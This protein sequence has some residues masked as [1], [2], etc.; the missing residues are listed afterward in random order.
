[1]AERSEAVYLCAFTENRGAHEMGRIRRAGFRFA[2]ACFVG[3]PLVC[4]SLVYLSLACSPVLAADAPAPLYGRIDDARLRKAANEPANWL[5]YGGTYSEQRYSPLD[6][7]NAQTIAKLAPAWSFDFDTYRG[8]ESTPIVVDGVMYVTTAWSKVYAL[9]AKTGQQIWSHDPE[10]PGGAGPKPCCDVVNRGA[11]V[12]KGKVYVGTVDGR[13]IALDAR[14]GNLAWSTLTVDSKLMHSITGAPRVANGKVFI[15]NGGG[16]FGGRGYVSAYDAETGKLVWR[17]YTVPKDPKLPKDGAASDDA[18]ARIALPTW[19]GDWPAYKGGG[20]PWNAIVYDP[21]FNQLYIATGNGFPLNRKFRSDA[22]GD[23][24]FI[25][26]IVALN[27][28]TGKYRWHYQETP[29]DSWD[30]DSVQDMML[31][32]LKIGVESRKVL[33][34][35]PKNGFFYVLDRASGKLLSA[36]P[37]VPGITWAKGI[38]AATGRPNV[39]PEAYYVNAPFTNHPGEGGAHGWQ[40]F[41]FSPKTGLVYVPAA[42]NSTYFVAPEKYE[43]ID[44]I[45]NPGIMHGALPPTHGA[46]AAARPGNKS[47][48]LAWDP[49]AKKA[50]WR[51]NVLGGGGTVVV[52]DLVFQGRS[53]DGVL[54]ELAAFRADTGEEI[55]SY[56]TPNAILQSPV[57]YE[58]AGEQYIAAASG[59]GGANI[60]FGMEPAHVRQA[61]RMVVF[62]LNGTGKFPADPPRAPAPV[63]PSQVWPAE[64]VARGKAHYAKFCGR[65]HGLNMMSANIV[66]DLRRSAA[67]ADKDAWQSIVIGGALEKQGMISWA[68]LITP[69]DAE[70]IRGYVADEARKL[71]ST[72]SAA[73]GTP[74]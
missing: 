40:P 31:A 16:E 47:Y 74:R 55:W 42:E 18:L 32:D 43:Y 59:A 10:V 3:M 13:L 38:D 48:L 69:A 29:G 36:T 39:D 52:G 6:Q 28:D 56:K 24:L 44:G 50:A 61:G 73:G 27:A 15:G 20:H 34:H 53:R 8:Q 51:T 57:T 12:Y 14:T 26:S 64:A 19:H 7:I 17:F 49:V 22:Q 70:A 11:A 41:S 45:D 63:P 9:D 25:A 21:A 46:N 5:T 68:K 1:M 30:F 60:L 54:G 67:L 35:A 58:I 71:A 4:I 33:L 2:I 66:P 23:N 72:V 37:Y 62:K 65:C